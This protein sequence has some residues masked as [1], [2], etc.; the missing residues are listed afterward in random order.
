MDLG[1]YADFRIHI[2]CKRFIRVIVEV[3]AMA[4]SRCNIRYINDCEWLEDDFDD[5]R[6]ECYVY[7]LTRTRESIPVVVRLGMND[8]VRMELSVPDGWKESDTSVGIE[9]SI[10]KGERED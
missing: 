7:L 5:L 9:R 8:I 1:V 4:S 2:R 6:D 10:P 3:T